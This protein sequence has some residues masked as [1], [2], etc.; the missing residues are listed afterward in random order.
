VVVDS[1]VGT[2]RRAL[3]VAAG[4]RFFV[5]PDNGVFSRVLCDA[6]ATLVAIED[7]T[8]MRGTISA[9]FHGRDIFAPAAA[10]LSLGRP[11]AALG[12]PVTEPVLLALPVPR[13]DGEHVRGEVV[14]VDVF[15][16]LITNIGADLAT[17]CRQVM[18]AGTSCALART[19]AAAGAG[20]LVAVIGSRGVLEISV[21][22]GSAAALLHAARG[23]PVAV[24]RG[25][26]APADT[27][28]AGG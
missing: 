14:H 5:G 26:G 17:G 15:G 2:A 10:H 18:V 9:T 13:A 24:Q 11:L 6:D 22:G 3:A 21:R 4:A 16:N 28:G 19:Y 1:G 27:T 7:E 12:P 23:T 20:E 25:A 8:I